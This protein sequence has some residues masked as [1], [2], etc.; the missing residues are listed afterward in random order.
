MIWPEH[1]LDAPPVVHLPIGYS[2]RTYQPGDESRF[3]EIMHLAGWTDFEE[4]KLRLW[5]YRTLPDGWFMAVHEQSHQIV[6]TAMATHDHTWQVPFCGE[7][8]WI[9]TDP[10]HTSKG[11]G[12]AVVAAVTLRFLEMGYRTI[13]LYTEIF[14]LPAIKI[15]L[16]LGYVPL[17]DPPEILEHWK[18]I[19]A[20]LSWPITPNDWAW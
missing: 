10:A 14:R 13:H 19:C 18:R 3:L 17:L 2:L 6:A 4:Q 15:Y 5:H 12:T 20:Q 7:V 1:L 16:R 11:L 9:A 8:G